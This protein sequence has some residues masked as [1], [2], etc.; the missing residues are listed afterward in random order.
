MKYEFEKNLLLVYYHPVIFDLALTFKKLFRNVEICVTNDLKD[1]Y[2][3]HEDVIKK[4]ESYGLKCRLINQAMIKLR[5]NQYDLVGLDGVFQ[6][7]KLII[8]ACNA[9]NVP[10]FAISGYPHTLDEPAKNIL[11]FSWYMPQMQ[12]RHK[13]PSEAHVKQLNWSKIADLGYDNEQKNFFVFYPEFS[14][15]KKFRDQQETNERFHPNFFSMIHRF[16]ECNEKCFKVFKDIKDML[17]GELI[18]YTS[19]TQT[20]VWQVMMKSAGLIHLKHGDCPGIALLESMLLGRVPFVMKDFVLASHNQ[21]VLIDE[22]SAMVCES[23]NEIAVRAIAHRAEISK[24]A[25][26][27]SSLEASTMKHANML[28]NFDRQKSGLILFFIKCLK[29]V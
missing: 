12:Y 18:N 28:T 14:E 7:D 1:N 9:F 5:T 2:G 10:Y 8:D 3:T 13:Y 19:L 15:L 21:E 6:G 17:Q 4:A 16:E 25:Y 26:G 27:F 11:S 24:I 23:K 22:Y 29:G 20:E